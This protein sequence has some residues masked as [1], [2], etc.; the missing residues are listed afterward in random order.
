MIKPLGDRVLL[1]KIEA[2]EIT[3]GG[4]IVTGLA[5]TKEAPQECEVIEVGPGETVDGK[6]V[7]MEVKKGQ[8]VL[9]AKFSGT[10]VKH[11]GIEYIIVSQKDI[12]AIVE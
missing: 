3:K 4:V 7:P 6:Q 2:E 5:R 9:T 12:L 8:K 11:E 10:E 1:K